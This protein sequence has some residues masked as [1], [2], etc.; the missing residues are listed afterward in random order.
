MLQAKRM[1]IVPLAR[2]ASAAARAGAGELLLRVGQAAIDIALEP[3][4]DVGRGE[5]IDLDRLAEQRRIGDEH[6][7]QRCR[8]LV[9]TIDRTWRLSI[10]VPAGSWRARSAASTILFQ[11]SPARSRCQE[12]CGAEVGVG[13]AGGTAPAEPGR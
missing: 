9:S 2:K 6:L 3:V 8:S 13:L 1:L 7:A 12:P 5:Q 4:V 10:S 11:L